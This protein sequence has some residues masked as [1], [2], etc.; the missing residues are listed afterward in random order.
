M[1]KII[2]LFLTIVFICQYTIAQ[3][4]SYVPTDGLVGYWPFDGNANDASGNGNNGV[5]NGPTLTSDRFGNNNSAYSFTV[6]SSAGW[7]SAQDRITITN[8]T[9]PNDNSFAMSGW[10]NLESKPGPFID[11]PHTLMGRWDGNGEAVFRNYINYSGQVQTALYPYSQSGTNIYESGNVTYG[12]WEHVVITYD[13]SVVKHY[14]NGQLTGQETLNINIAVSSTNIT[15]GELHMANGHW[16][17]FSGKMDDLGYWSRAL[18]QQEI[19]DLYESEVL[20]CD[21]DI[22][23]SATEVCAGESVDLSTVGD[24]NSSYLWSTGESNFS[25][26]GT[27]LDEYSLVANTVSQNTFSITPGNNYRLEVLGT[28]SLGAGSGNQKDVAYY[29]QSGSDGTIEGTP[30][31]SACNLIIWTSLFCDTPALRPTPDIY[32]SSG[33]TYNYPFTAN[34]STLDVGFWDSPIGDNGAN[35]VTFKLYE[36]SSS[37][38]T[39][40]VI[41]TET[42]EY[43]VDVTTNGVTCRE[44]VT[45]NVTA[46]EA[47]TGDSE[48]TFCSASTIADLTATGD[49]IQ[50][51]DTATGGNLLDTTSTLT[52]GQM[53]Y[54]S[55][56]VNDCE[57]SD[58]L[59]VTVSIQDITITASATEICAGES[60]DLSV[61]L[62][63]PT[64]C[65]MQI[66]L[67]DVP[68][69]QEI[70]GFTYGGFYNEHH[71]YVYNNP[72]SWTDGEQISRENGGYLVCINDESENTF[73]SNLTNNNIWIGLFRDPETCEFRWLD[74]IDINYT[75]WRPGEPNSGPCGEPYTQIIRGCSFGYNTWNNLS[76][77]PINGPCYSNMVPI[78]EIDPEIY[79]TFDPSTTY[80][81]STGDTTETI[82][83][84]P[85]ETTEYWVDVTTNG[86]TCREYVT[87]NVDTTA[88]EITCLADQTANIE[89]SCTYEIP[90]YTGLATA[91]D[92]CVVTGI[93]QDPAPGTLV[94]LG[95]TTITLTASDGVNTTDCSFVLTV[96]DIT[97]PEISCLA[98]QLESADTGCMFTV[99]DYTGLATAT[100]NCVVTGITQDPAPGTLVALG[101]TTITL[102]A[103]DG[104]NTTDCSFALTVADI[105]APEISCLADQLE[106]ADTGCMFTVPDYTGL[107]T[108]TDNCVVTGI[109]QDPAPGTLVALG[110]T[111][112]TLTASDGV[113]TTDCSF[114]LTVADITAP[115][116][117]CLADQTANIETSCTYE[118]PDYTGL[119]TATDNCVVTGITQD[120]A[121][122]TLVALGDTT[123]TLTA[124][125]GVNTTD[126]SF[127]LTVADITAP[128]ISCLADQLESAD[129]GC[130]FTVPDYTGLA[131]ATDNCVVTGI[132]QDPA[133]GT[134]V[135]LGDTTITLTASDG[136][137]TTDC[138]FALTVADI[139][140]PE[141]SCLADQL[142]GADTGC[143]FTVP[144]YTGLATATD[145]CV[146]TG[147]TQDPAPGT[148]VALGDTTITLTASDGVNTTD[149]S[150]VLTVAD[151]TA[152]EISCL[153]DQTANIETSC[154]YEIPDYTGLATATDNCVVTG[155]TQDPAPGTLVALGDTTITLTASD[156]VNT[157][158]CSFVLT[159]ADITAPTAICQDITIELGPEGTAT[160]SSA[161]ID[162]GSYDNCGEVTYELNPNTFDCSDIG[163]NIVN[164]LV[165]DSN[166]LASECFAT[167]IVLDSAPPIAICQDITVALDE[168]YQAIITAAD[169]DAGSTDNCTISNT[170]IDINTFD[171]SNLGTNTVTL[172][173]TDQNGNEAS[174]SAIVTVIEGVFTPNAVCQNVT[175]TLG[176]DGTATAPA[177]AFDAGSTG[178]R[179]VDGLSID[180]DNFSCADIGTLIE[181]E[182]TV[183]NAAGNT[184]S[185]TAYVN[186]VDGISPEI[187]CPEDQTVT[188]EGPYP[189]PNYFETGQAIVTDNC[190]DLITVF[191]QSPTAGTLMPEGV[192]I[193][194]LSTQDISGFTAECEF[195]LT[196][197]DNLG[198][199]NTTALR[200]I[201]MYPNPA[202]DVITLNNPQNINLMSISIYDITGR[203]I[204]TKDLQS[205]SQE[206]TINIGALQSGNYLLFIKSAFGQIT[207][208]LLKQ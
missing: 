156:G 70:P 66:N 62:N 114:V 181:V 42:T 200:A 35:V 121:P 23:T 171:C 106:S 33:H 98:D 129:T 203:L 104:V 126:C 46:P 158:D 96:A 51:Y 123:I 159:V 174:C 97:A 100:D 169:I 133:P 124:S 64:I 108:A 41:P 20:S 116:I 38:S 175:V 9:I 189:L 149:C 137:N 17:L 81:W 183:T 52:A 180:I 57:S 34:S 56:T 76:N 84:I 49:N 192:H 157:T 196:I 24:I 195:T 162:N 173:M 86:V 93:T 154:T 204:I 95:D 160:I 92:N 182:F 117:S 73:V 19:T 191:N 205:A 113:N 143:M 153:A 7:G 101:D 166:G 74:C 120:P 72:T 10:V 122:G 201:T 178:A 39:I 21:V 91:T 5:V 89:T 29:I 16:Y 94:A 161:D 208:Q 139:T 164:L 69:G 31:D 12:N 103:S 115:E 50:W 170:T 110:D 186:V 60:V 119:A 40:T 15:F 44:Y 11:R 134:L 99:P 127:V 71:Y 4:P 58:R 75:N 105:T 142:E 146:V 65:D 6:N 18:T 179:C 83:V 188:S 193:I 150:F 145:N 167:V 184:D 68:L 111:T 37:E 54:A 187:T 198:T 202:N 55:Q 176:E 130:M 27:L 90:D 85:T 2:Y 140:A 53:V 148:L 88:P 59:E 87:I 199:Q 25:G 43:W 47:P 32:D 13:G 80:L 138:S 147:I 190:L 172:T 152:P 112:I 132:T 78:M 48:Q 141:I 109:T 26:Q 67:T 197:I 102:T 118:I 125:D 22:I 144:D 14:V 163:T 185:C 194:S 151:I 79:Q 36:L 45:I 82:T 155:I 61:N 131:T 3:V 207:K 30:F 128:E 177:S 206:S 168:E 1:K 28:V 135:A 77:N 107:A 136:V 8:P 165:F 63:L